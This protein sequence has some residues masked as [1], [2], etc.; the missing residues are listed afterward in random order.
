MN[1][2]RFTL[3]VLL[4]L[5]FAELASAQTHPALRETE[6]ADEAGGLG[7]PDCGDDGG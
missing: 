1:A 3:L 6:L 4:T 5:A 2:T 7:V